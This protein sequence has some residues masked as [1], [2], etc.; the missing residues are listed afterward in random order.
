VP[1]TVSNPATFEVSS[2][3]DKA[4]VSPGGN[5]KLHLI[6]TNKG[7]NAGNMRI[8]ANSSDFLLKDT[9]Q[10]A[11]GDL[12]ANG[13]KETDVEFTVSSSLSGGTYSIPIKFTYEDDLGNTNNE[14]ANVGPIRVVKS[15]M[16]FGIAARAGNNNVHP[17]DKFDLAL[18]ITNNGGEAAYASVVTIAT[19]SRSA[20]YFVALDTSERGVG[21]LAAGETKTANFRMGVNGNAVPGYYALNA[22]IN[23]VNSQGESARISKLFGV[24]VLGVYDV[25]VI[26]EPS[27]KPVTA[28]RVYSL[29]TQVSNTGTGKLK[30]VSAELYS[31]DDVQ[32]IGTP[33]GFIG[34]LDVGDYS[35]T[36][37][38]V[39]VKPGLAPG[40]YPM[41]INV[42]FFDAYNKEHVVS[43]VAYIDVVSAD[44]A[45]LASGGS[46]GMSGTTMLVLLL[47]IAA[48]LWY[49]NKKGRLEGA[50]AFAHAKLGPLLSKKKK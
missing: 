39:Y 48:A 12:D 17:G 36:Q 34:E 6:I 25:S 24:E 4:Q 26:A 19:D 37:Y 13:V 46:T 21:D 35:S 8:S 22:T 7:G 29:S 40:R 16:D 5:V 28:G 18:D 27:P 41:R 45:A 20:D 42:T 33:Y 3:A 23:F 14:Q 9:S 2:S 1:V 32:V 49:A 30:A 50:K 11:L 43:K 38:D 47:I 10:I 44:I 15:S 31:T